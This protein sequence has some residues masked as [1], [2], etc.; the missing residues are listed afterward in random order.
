LRSKSHSALNREAGF[1]LVEA[2]AALAILAVSLGAIGALG[3]AN[4]R[5]GVSFENHF[6]QIETARRILTALPGRGEPQNGALKGV[7]DG[8]EWRIDA[9]PYAPPFVDPNTP[10]PWTPQ[11]LAARVLSPGGSLIE[12][13]TIRLRRRPPH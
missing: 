10:N 1:T 9:R 13:D 2:L 12:I 7:M 4:L 3:A 5:S 8:Y 6:A 11:I